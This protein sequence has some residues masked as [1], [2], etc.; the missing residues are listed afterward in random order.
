MELHKVEVF[1][2]GEFTTVDVYLEGREIP[3][4]EINNNQYYKLY[5]KLPVYGS[6]DVHV[7]LKGWISMDWELKIKVDDVER[8]HERGTFGQ[9]GFA[10]FT[11][12]I[13]T[14]LA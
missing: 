11:R 4:Q 13:K 14:Q 1:L 2:N 6:L 8:L 12:N 7:R 5:T 10:T 9:W 3:L